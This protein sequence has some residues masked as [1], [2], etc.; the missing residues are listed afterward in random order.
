MTE[1]MLRFDEYIATLMSGEYHQTRNMLYKNDRHGERYC[2]LGVAC[3]MVGLTM[4]YDSE[5]DGTVVLVDEDQSKY[6]FYSLIPEFLVVDER[7]ERISV[8]VTIGKRSRNFVGLLPWSMLTHKATLKDIEQ[9]IEP[10]DNSS[11]MHD[12]AR[13]FRGHNAPLG[14]VWV[15]AS[16]MNDEQRSFKTIARALVAADA[17]V[18]AVEE[19][20]QPSETLSTPPPAPEGQIVG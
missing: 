2:C 18:T 4:K 1:K 5:D 12:I 11:I 9:T 19:R 10:L 15:L 6:E 13:T 3:H 14:M 7:L 17:H 8:S 20:Q 16:W